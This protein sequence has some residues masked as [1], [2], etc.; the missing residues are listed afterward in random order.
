MSPHMCCY[1]TWLGKLSITNCA[2]K[3]FF[4]AVSSAMGCQVCRLAEWLVTQVT[5]KCYRHRKWNQPDSLL[6]C[7]VSHHY[8]FSGGSSRSMVVRNP[9]HKFG[10]HFS[11]QLK[12]P[13]KK[14]RRM[15]KLPLLLPFRDHQSLTEASTIIVSFLCFIIPFRY[16][17][18]IYSCG[19]HKKRVPVI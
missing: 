16:F 14:G 18:K 5:S 15:E 6:T 3:G 9:C 13:E 12:S 10:R 7:K 2:A 17:I 4:P 1:G 11:H 19:N 8:G